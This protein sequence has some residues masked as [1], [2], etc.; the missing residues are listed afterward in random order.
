MLMQCPSCPQYQKKKSGRRFFGYPGSF[1]TCYRLTGA[2]TLIIQQPQLCI[3]TDA[4]DKFD[5]NVMMATKSKGIDVV[6]NFL[7][8]S[9]LKTAFRTMTYYSKFF[10]FSTSDL[11]KNE[12]LGEWP[13][14]WLVR[15]VDR[16]S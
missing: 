11:K 1:L 6:L 7:S 4:D 3:I 12:N 15:Q 10:H 13:D 2:S 8:G 5:I 16:I 9:A 14:I